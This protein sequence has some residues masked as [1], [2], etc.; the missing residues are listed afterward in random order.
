MQSII[1]RFIGFESLLGPG[2]VKVVYYFGAAAIVLGG[3]FAL[4]M[5]LV[6]L[7]GGNIGAGLMQLLAVPAVAAVAL[8]YWRFLC[9]LFMLAFLAYER[10][11]EIRN[12]MRIA[13]GEA[14]APDPNHPAF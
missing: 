12:S 1:G 9:E 2:L 13:T 4:M 5:A 7:F 11:T 8:V 6:S 14:S 10:L 3:G